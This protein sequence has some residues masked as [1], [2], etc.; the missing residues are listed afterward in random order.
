[1]GSLLTN[2]EGFSW[3]IR[4]SPFFFVGYKLYQLYLLPVKQFVISSKLSQTGG[5]P[6]KFNHRILGTERVIPSKPL[7]HKIV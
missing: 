5:C 2:M 7:I 3:V 1:M 4:L 6:L